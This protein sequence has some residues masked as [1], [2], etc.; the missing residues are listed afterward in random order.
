MI[1]TLSGIHGLGKTTFVNN[2]LAK[3]PLFKIVNIDI[4]PE[5]KNQEKDQEHLERLKKFY[6]A[7]ENIKDFKIDVLIDRSPI[8]FCVYINWWLGDIK[9]YPNLYK[10]FK[11]IIKEYKKTDYRNILVYEDS[12]I[13]WKRIMKRSR[14][15]YDEKNLKYFNYCYKNFYEQ[16]GKNFEK[17]TGIKSDFV[18]LKNLNE[19]INKILT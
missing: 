12:D 18:S 7:L 3:K 6:Y 16:K 13:V 8:D 11:K 1:I 10:N 19:T 4:V 9:Q 14:A 17:L 5:R 2:Y 15:Q